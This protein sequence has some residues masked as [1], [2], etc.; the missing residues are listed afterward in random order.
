MDELGPMETK[1][2]G[3][4]SHAVDIIEKLT[5]CSSVFIPST[6]ARVYDAKCIL[7]GRA[8]RSTEFKL[9]SIRSD[10]SGKHKGYFVKVPYR[11]EGIL[12]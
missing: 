4:R 6:R 8:E 1:S 2:I 11:I 3:K 9:Q 10:G 5:A 12:F 7:I